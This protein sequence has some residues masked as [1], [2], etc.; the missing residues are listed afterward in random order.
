MR[1]KWYFIKKKLKG[2]PPSWPRLTLS[3][4][5]FDRLFSDRDS[6]TFKPTP[7]L[8][9]LMRE[10]PSALVVSSGTFDKIVEDHEDGEGKPTQALLE[11]MAE[12]E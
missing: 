12:D 5:E 8:R 2:F 1:C 11:L 10:N 9:A 3:N 7:A 4:E 6:K